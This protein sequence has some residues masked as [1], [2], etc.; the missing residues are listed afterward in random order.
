MPRLIDRRCPRFVSLPSDENLPI[1]SP[2][3]PFLK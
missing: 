3:E 2:F 1:V